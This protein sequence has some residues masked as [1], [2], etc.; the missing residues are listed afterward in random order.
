MY[1]SSPWTESERSNPTRNRG[2]ALLQIHHGNPSLAEI[3]MAAG[4]MAGGLKTQA[5]ACSGSE[6]TFSP[7]NGPGLLGDFLFLPF[8]NQPMGVQRTSNR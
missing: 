6:S 7:P 5:V 2:G 4:I 8:S 3:F 1:K